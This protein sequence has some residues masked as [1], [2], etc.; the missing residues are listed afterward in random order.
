MAGS[1]LVATTEP[2]TRA[3]NMS[4][5]LRP[6]GGYFFAGV[7]RRLGQNEGDVVVRARDDLHA[8]DFADRAGGLGAG[9]GGG[10]D[11]G[12]VTRPRRR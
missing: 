11:G 5:S 4:V 2:M 8:D 12:D 6:V 10:F 3:M 7:A 1:F 9:V